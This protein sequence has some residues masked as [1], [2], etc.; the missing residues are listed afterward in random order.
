MP[1]PIQYE[2]FGKM[3]FDHAPFIIA[4]VVAIIGATIMILKKLGFL[5]FDKKESGKGSDNEMCKHCSYVNGDTE[6]AKALEELKRQVKCDTH[7]SLCE[8]VKTIRATQLLME[9]QQ[10]ANIKALSN[11]K[12]EFDKLHSR[13]STMNDKVTDLRI[14]M[15]VLLNKLGTKVKEF[16][17][18]KVD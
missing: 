7:D 14:G 10:K 16:S 11:G 8:T 2:S 6:K 9:Q 12:N 4:G 17:D 3:I 13:M 15:A 1:D 18:I 5:D